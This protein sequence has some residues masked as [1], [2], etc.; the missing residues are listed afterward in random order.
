VPGI[1]WDIST[2]RQAVGCHVPNDAGECVTCLKLWGPPQ[3][4]MCW[5]YEEAST[6]IELHE[7]QSE[8]PSPY[9]TIAYRRSGPGGINN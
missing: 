9:R 3:P 1:E 2:A 4:W 6:F 7:I 5:V 8:V